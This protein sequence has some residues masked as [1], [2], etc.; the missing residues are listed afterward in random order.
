VIYNNKSL[1]VLKKNVKLLMNKYEWS[2]SRYRNYR[3][4]YTRRS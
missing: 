3:F 4:V 2:I 1:K